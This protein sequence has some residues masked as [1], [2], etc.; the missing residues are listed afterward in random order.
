MLN[1]GSMLQR[2][3]SD[4]PNFKFQTPI[5]V[6]SE[7]RS[8]PAM[9]VRIRRRRRIRVLHELEGRPLRSCAKMHDS[10]SESAQARA[11]AWSHE[12]ERT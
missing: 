12:S 2:R 8:I 11:R 10:D 3:D 7:S 4:S 6:R 1:A 9:M 5:D